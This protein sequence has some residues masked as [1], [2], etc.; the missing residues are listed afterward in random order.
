MTKTIDFR[1]PYERR[2]DLVT[3]VVTDHSSLKKDEAVDL[4]VQ[5]LHAIDHIPE[6]VR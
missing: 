6:N 5:I 2:V 1:T 3:A 4:A